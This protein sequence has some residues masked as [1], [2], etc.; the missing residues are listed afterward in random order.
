MGGGQSSSLGYLD[1]LIAKGA[2]NNF[3]IFNYHTY[4]KKDGVTSQ[5]NELKAKVGSKP[6]WITEV[7]YPSSVADQ[8][9]YR[10][11]YPYSSGED[12]QEEYLREILPHILSLGVEKVFWYT[13]ADVPRDHSSF[14]TYGLF[15]I[16]EKQCMTLS[17]SEGRKIDGELTEKKAFQAYKEITAEAG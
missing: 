11:S 4:D 10:S 17:E 6:I 13:S 15:Y 1:T 9:K 8:E 12:G 3:D 14:C 5:Y 2:L 16:P 7:G